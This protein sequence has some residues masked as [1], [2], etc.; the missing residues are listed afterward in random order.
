MPVLS[1]D[2]AAWSI[3]HQILTRSDEKLIALMTYPCDEQYACLTVARENVGRLH[4]VISINLNGTGILAGDEVLR[5]QER[6]TTAQV[7]KLADDAAL[8]AELSLNREA[9]PFIVM[10]FLLEMLTTNKGL[11]IRNA[12]HDGAYGSG[13]NEAATAF[14]HYPIA[15]TQNWQEHIPWW[16]ILYGHTPIAACNLE[17][18]QLILEN[19]A[20]LILATD[21]GSA[22]EAVRR[23]VLQQEF[24]GVI[25]ETRKLLAENPEWETRYKGYAEDIQIN[26]SYIEKVRSSF[27][28]WAPLMLYMNVSNAK[29]AKQHLIFELRYLGQTVAQLRYKTALL[30]DTIG[31]DG[32]NQR[33]FGCTLSAH[34]VPWDSPTAAAFRAYFKTNPPRSNISGKRNKEHRLESLLLSEFSKAIDKPLPFIQPVKVAKL[35]FPMPTPISASD[36]NQVTYSCYN[37]GGIDL[38]ARIGKGK[39]TSLSILELKDE[40]IAKEP[41]KDALKQAI[42]YTVFIRELLRS[43]A[44][45]DWWRLFGFGGSIPDKL[46]LIAACVMPTG[47]Y[48]DES[49]AGMEMAVDEDI[50]R[51]NYIYFTEHQNAIT[52]IRTSLDLKRHFGERADQ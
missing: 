47:Q 24:L 45:S 3:L 33:D 44:G 7:R 48:D 46:K 42:A 2:A 15:S 22:I 34:G 36:H 26:E 19:G 29:K 5:Y 20:H 39:G 30:L 25:A 31:Y 11:S 18:G 43:D 27:H 40:N 35:R 1:K 23:I 50:I 13:L 4:P 8:Q 38:F 12:W 6:M 17:T 10:D 51:L 14:S 41:P 16:I 21:N 37:G 52:D 49:F 28:E 32:L 9:R